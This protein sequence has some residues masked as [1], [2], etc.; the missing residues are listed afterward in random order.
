MRLKFFVSL[1]LVVGVT[2][3]Y[4]QTPAVCIPEPITIDLDDYPIQADD[5]LIYGSIDVVG[6]FDAETCVY[7]LELDWPGFN[8]YSI[9]G[10][11]Y[12]FEDVKGLLTFKFLE[13]FY[14]DHI[15]NKDPSLTYT[16]NFFEKKF[17][18]Y[19]EVC[20]LEFERNATTDCVDPGFGD[21]PI[22]IEGNTNRILSFVSEGGTCGYVCCV[23]PVTFKPGQG[24]I[25]VD[26]IQI[27]NSYQYSSFC[28]P[29]AETDCLT[30]EPYECVSPSCDYVKGGS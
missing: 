19:N 22:W 25:I 12:S 1:I 7:N 4:A 17:C 30:G 21:P 9:N 14:R 11:Q 16:V 26:N 20:Y 5:F 13:A 27:L 8:P 6:S 2:T 23:T 15:D 24:S 18:T 29:P 28:E 3:I 10:K